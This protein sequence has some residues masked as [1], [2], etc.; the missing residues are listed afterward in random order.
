MKI[1]NI[2]NICVVMVMLLPH[3]I[4]MCTT[5]LTE[6]MKAV[7]KCNLQ[8]KDYYNILIKMRLKTGSEKNPS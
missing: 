2:V 5:Y 7:L 1:L 8:A 4:I 3:S 6:V